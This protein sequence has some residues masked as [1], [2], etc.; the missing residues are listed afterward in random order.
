LVREVIRQ[1][2]GQE[3][4][5]RQFIGSF[6][7]ELEHVRAHPPES[8]DALGASHQALKRLVPLLKRMTREIEDGACSLFG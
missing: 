5:N 1:H 4:V 2:H 6:R 8:R 3:Q 7:A